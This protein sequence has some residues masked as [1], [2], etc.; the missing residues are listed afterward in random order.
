MSPGCRLY[1]DKMGQN[2]KIV[3]EMGIDEMGL[4]EMGINHNFTII[5]M[6]LKVM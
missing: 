6:S 4:D 3:G 5:L 2:D 1:V